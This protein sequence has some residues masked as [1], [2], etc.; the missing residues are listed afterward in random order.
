MDF[1]SHFPDESTDNAATTFGNMEY[2][3]HWMYDNNLF[4]KDI[5][6]YNTAYGQMQCG[7]Y[8]SDGE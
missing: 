8:L 4:I 6:L 7:Y 5:I 1:H 2:F 3:I